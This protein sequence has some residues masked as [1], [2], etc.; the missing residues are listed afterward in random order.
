MSSLILATLT[1]LCA[2]FTVGSIADLLID[3]AIER[4]QRTHT[5]PEAQPCVHTR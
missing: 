2:G 4:R 1:G 5:T 3:L